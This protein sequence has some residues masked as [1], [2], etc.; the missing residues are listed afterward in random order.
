LIAEGHQHSYVNA[1]RTGTP[2]SLAESQGFT[3]SPAFADA[4]ARISAGQ[5]ITCELAK[6]VGVVFHAIS[7]AHHA[8]YGQGVV[9]APFNFL[10]GAAL[11]AKSRTAIVDLDAHQDNGTFD[12]VGGKAKVGLFDISHASRG[13]KSPAAHQPYTV[14]SDA[15]EYFEQFAELPHFL[16][17]FEPELVQY[18]AG[19]DC[20]EKDFMGDIVGMNAESL[21]ARDRF[22]IEQVRL[23]RIPI[24]IN[25]GGG[26]VD[27]TVSLHVQTALIATQVLVS[28]TRGAKT[29]A[30]GVCVARMELR[31]RRRY[32]MAEKHNLTRASE[33]FYL[34]ENG[35]R[36]DKNF[37]DAMMGTEPNPE[38]PDLDAAVDFVA[39]C[40]A[41]GLPADIVKV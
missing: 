17:T 19:V 31:H 32:S 27:Q 30:Q 21:G 28:C 14:A 10:A 13:V 35:K 22:V 6:D 4:V 5:L 7:G 11:K 37:W 1:V 3:R 36:Q 24:V 39:F 8:L 9:S 29:A 38:V 2:R 18:Q 34:D 15:K 23:R 12:L 26:Y 33:G 41:R 40:Q 20:F 16:D 25:P